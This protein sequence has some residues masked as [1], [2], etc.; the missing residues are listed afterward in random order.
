MAKKKKPNPRGA[1]PIPRKK[2]KKEWKISLPKM[3]MPTIPWRW[4]LLPIFSGFLAFSVHW[5]YTSTPVTAIEFTGALNVWN[6][7]QLTESLLWIKDESFFSL[8]VNKVHQQLQALPLVKHVSVRKRWPGTI[9]IKV[10]EDVPIALWNNDKVLSASGKVSVLPEGL[11]TEGLVQM[12]GPEQQTEQVVRYYRRLQQA[13]IDQKLRVQEL[14]VSEVGS[15]EAKLSNGWQVK[16]GRQYI[17]ERVER[18]DRILR[19]FPQ[20]KVDIVDLRYGKGAAIRWRE[21]QEIG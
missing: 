6:A 18:L 10:S 9:D 11:K 7:E 8:D 12:S 21:Q 4:I 1:T 2:V 13:L 19:Y 16:L 5:V 15:V 17:E 20:E 3:A 14:S